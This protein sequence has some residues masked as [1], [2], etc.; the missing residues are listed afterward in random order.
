[1][2][3]PEGARTFLVSPN[4]YDTF[5]GRFSRPLALK[6]VNS[7]P[8]LRGST[9]L[10]V[11]C[12]PGALTGAL[13]DMLGA[14]AVSVVDPSPPFLAA[15]LAQYPDVTGKQ[16]RAEA[17]PYDDDSFDAVL[18]QLVLFFLSDAEAAGLEMVR[19]AKVGGL[20]ASSI[21]DRSRM[22]MMSR[23]WQSAGVVI[24]E[25]PE[26][27][28]EAHASRFNSAGNLASYFDS[29]GLTDISESE[30]SVQAEFVDFEELWLGYQQGIGPIGAWC[31]AQSDEI[32]SAIKTEL[33]KNLGSPTG[34]FT[35]SA[36]ALTASGRTPA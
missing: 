16:G 19:V 15:C 26:E 17:L 2:Q 21:W 1:M 7:L 24:G 32:Q 13:V 4:M 31:V 35:L 30:I 10:D 18:S 12:G 20:L 36:I 14:D 23:F 22:E 33:F 34:S 29:L 9:A 5:M 28:H 11:G 25:G 6:F 8:L 3:T 27:P